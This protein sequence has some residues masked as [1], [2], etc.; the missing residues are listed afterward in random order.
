MTATPDTTATLSMFTGL[1]YGENKLL[2]SFAKVIEFDD[3]ATIFKEGDSG[4]RMFIV[5]AG[6]VS[7]LKGAREIAL[8]SQGR[9]FGEMSMMDGRRRSATCVASGK[10]T[11]LAL[12]DETMRRM[13]KE[14]PA[15]AA[16]VY[17]S[18]AT[19]ISGRLRRADDKLLEIL[20]SD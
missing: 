8:M 6:K 12:D 11:L 1:P 18:I 3:G 13:L 15:V 14:A 10:C 2:A 7:V 16:R 17:Q 19:S 20:W 5:H 9:A 4:T